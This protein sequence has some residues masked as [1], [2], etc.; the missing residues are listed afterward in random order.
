MESSRENNKRIA[1]NT[2]FLYIRSLA[3]L[4]IGL[5]TVR[6]VLKALG[7]EDYGL[8]AVVGGSIGFLTFI[9]SALATGSQRFF[10]FTLGKGDM[11]EIKNNFNV[12]YSIY[13]VLIFIIIALSES[14]G[15]WFINSVLTIPEGRRLAANIIFQIVIISTG[16]S[17]ISTPY[18]MS[19]TA[20]EDMHLF[21]KM[22]ILDAII[23][24]AIC[25]LLV[26]LPVDKL[27]A[28]GVM[29]LIGTL[30]VQGIYVGFA[31]RNYEECRPKLSWDKKRIKEITSFSFWNLFGS[32][33][34]VGKTQG[35]SVILNIFHGPIVNAAQGIA[36]T[37]R[38]ASSTFS[39]GF[40]IALTPQIVKKYAV[41]DYS[42]MRSLVH[43]GSKMSFYLMMVVVLPIIL[44]ID[45]LLQIWLGDYSEHVAPFC[46]IIL[47][48]ALLDSI[49]LP[50]AT[51]NQATG[52]IALYQGLIG[53][54]GF[55][56]VPFAYIF[57]KLGYAPEWVLVSSL[58]F[59]VFVIG[60]RVMFLRR[61]YPQ[62]VKGAIKSV[63]LPCIIVGVCSFGIC[64]LLGIKIDKFITCVW[65]VLLYVGICMV[66]IWIIGLTK[67]ERQ[68]IC[69]TISSK[70]RNKKL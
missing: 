37:V 23:K 32:F 61:V 9:T 52:K 26:I 70:I 54:F 16:V 22:A 65:A 14:V 49:S 25:V 10:S 8:Y 11:T 51:A 68:Y 46:Q 15:V 53:F 44:S 69:G 57:M 38:N 62:A 45:Y 30:L 67:P 27:I 48:E 7:E 40:G 2:I 36:N 42:S 18:Q 12:T 39:N 33:A 5:F 56:T 55:L 28:Y 34:W 1:K 41:N 58:I 64:M 63:I 47:M 6:Y 17:L 3:S 60:V 50:M 59:Q 35:V 13:V 24:I 31:R 4:F 20:H 43:R 29:L 21:G 19:I 66:V